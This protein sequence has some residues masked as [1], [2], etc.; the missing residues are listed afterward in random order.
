M[1]IFQILQYTKLGK[2]IH[3]KAGNKLEQDPRPSCS[4]PSRHV[5]VWT[6]LR[7][8]EKRLGSPLDPIHRLSVHQSVPPL[9]HGSFVLSVDGNL[10]FWQAVRHMLCV[11]R[12][13]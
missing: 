3:F 9:C 12:K 11:G 1:A 6:T 2:Y 10:S 4:K 7:T 8:E 13:F 5:L